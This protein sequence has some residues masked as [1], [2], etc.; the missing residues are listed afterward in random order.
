[1]GSIPNRFYSGWCSN[2]GNPRSHVLHYIIRTIRNISDYEGGIIP[3]EVKTLEEYFNLDEQAN[4]DPYYAIYITFKFDIPKGTI[5]VFETNDL[6]TAIFVVE[7]L[8]GNKVIEDD[9]V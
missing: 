1:M 8:S 4:E 2:A 9:I 7:E 6:K 3:E 5:K